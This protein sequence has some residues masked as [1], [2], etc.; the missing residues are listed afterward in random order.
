[1]VVKRQAR[2]LIIILS[3]LNIPEIK[4]EIIIGMSIG[5]ENHIY[6]LNVIQ[7]SRIIWK[8]AIEML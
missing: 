7:I 4:K 6:V 5:I 3:G 2:I 1:M 8:I